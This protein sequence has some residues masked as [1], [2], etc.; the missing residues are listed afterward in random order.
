VVL[1]G[2]DVSSLETPPL[3]YFQVPRHSYLHTLLPEALRM[4]QHLLPPGEHTPWLEYNRLP[5]KW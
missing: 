3:L 2:G 5:L 1:H 4:L